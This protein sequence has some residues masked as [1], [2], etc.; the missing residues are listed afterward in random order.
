MYLTS[1]SE[2][3]F[4]APILDVNGSDQ[5]AIIRFAPVLNVQGLANYDFSDHAGVFFGLS[6]RNLGFIYQDTANVRYKYRTYNVGLPLGFKLGRMHR[7]LFFAGYEI[8]LPFNYKEKRFENE[9]KEDKF[10]V[11]FS[12]RTE[13]FFQSVFFGM[14]APGGSTLTIRYYLSNFHNTDYVARKDNVDTK[15]YDGLNSNILSVSLGFGLFNG[16]TWD[17]QTP[18]ERN[19]DARR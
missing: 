15:P 14:Q 7:T 13:P 6:M 17:F 9:R 16:E 3:I 4:T 8:E 18:G 11:W 2:W 19:V 12:D 10:V 1:G 5:G